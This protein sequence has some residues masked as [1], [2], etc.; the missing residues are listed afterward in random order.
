MA[1]N[2][3]EGRTDSKETRDERKTRRVGRF[4]RAPSF[5]NGKLLNSVYCE[6]SHGSLTSPRY[7]VLPRLRMV[8]CVHLCWCWFDIHLP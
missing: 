7:F 1:R 4:S 8:V 3:L 5:K 2:I 6:S